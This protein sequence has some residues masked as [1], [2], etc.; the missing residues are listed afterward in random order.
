LR[1]DTAKL[2]SSSQQNQ[3]HRG[4]SS[5]PLTIGI[6]TLIAS[7]GKSMLLEAEQMQ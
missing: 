2:N 3:L 6:A 7:D 5:F 4:A 1:I